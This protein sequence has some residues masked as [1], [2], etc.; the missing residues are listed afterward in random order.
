MFISIRMS[1]DSIVGIDSGH[2][3]PL[4]F[5]DGLYQ[6]GGFVRVYI[7]KL[8]AVY[9]ENVVRI[10]FGPANLANQLALQFRGV[11]MEPGGS[12]PPG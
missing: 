9:H 8:S 10:F 4:L 11:L 6:P 2:S 12:D 7:A 5:N 1:L 3:T